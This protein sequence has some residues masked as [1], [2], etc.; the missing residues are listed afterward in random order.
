MTKQR[1]D[2]EGSVSLWKASKTPET[3]YYAR[4]RVTAPDGSAKRVTAY[5]RTKN[6]AIHAREAKAEAFISEHPVGGALSLKEVSAKWLTHKQHA[7]KSSTFHDY[8]KTLRIHILPH[9]GNRRIDTLTLLELQDC[10]NVPASEGK[11]NAAD[12]AR[13]VLK[14]IYKQALR[15]EL[16]EKNPAN[17]LDPI[18]KHPPKRGIWQPEQVE[19]FLAHTKDRWYYPLYYTTLSTGM[20]RGEVVAL[21]WQD[22]RGNS[23]FVNRTY[24]QVGKDWVMGPP[25]TRESKRRLPMSP[26]LATMMREHRLRL[27]AHAGKT[28]RDWSDQGLVFPSQTGGLLYPPNLRLRLVH[29]SQEIGLP[30]IRFHDLRRIYATSFIRAGGDPKQLQQRLGHATV[31]LAMEVYTSTVE[32]DNDDPIFD[33]A[34]LRKPTRKPTRSETDLNDLEMTEDDIDALLASEAVDDG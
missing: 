18:L 33:L 34:S 28:Q 6:L 10:L 13:K 12:K 1:A 8:A 4:R 23:I 14:M 17:M 20:R 16:T 30:R 29:Y 24:S 21:R 31:N 11:L 26:S 5:G 15:W 19:Q 22:V 32:E 27:E 9:L 7:I 3:R 2:G 25:K